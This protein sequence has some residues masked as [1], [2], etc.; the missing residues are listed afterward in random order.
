MESASQ[1]DLDHREIGFQQHLFGLQH[2]QFALF[3]LKR[4]AHDL[5]EEASEVS[6]AATAVAGELLAIKPDEIRVG[7]FLDQNA[8]PPDSGGFGGGCGVLRG[9]GFE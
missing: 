2:S 1:G 9:M 6:D 3:L 5:F 7:E 8:E 4:D